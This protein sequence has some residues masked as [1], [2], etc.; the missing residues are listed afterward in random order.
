VC[1]TPAASGAVAPC[2]T[3][4]ARV[5]LS[6]KELNLSSYKNTEELFKKLLEESKKYPRKFGWTRNAVNSYGDDLEQVKNC[7]Y[8]FSATEAENCRY[9]FFIP[10]E[11]KETYDVDHVGVGAEFIL[12][13]LS[14]FHDSRIAFGNRIYS[15]SDVFY[16]DDCHGSNNLFGCAGLRSKEYCILNKQYSKDEYLSLRKRIIKHMDEMPFEGKNGRVYKYGEFFPV[17]MSPFAY[18]EVVCQE[19]FQLTKDE[20]EAKGYRWRDSKKRRYDTT[21]Q[22]EDLPDNIEEVEDDILKQIVGCAHKGECD[23]QCVTAFK[24]TPQELQFLKAMKIPLPRLCPNCRHYQRL[25]QRNPLKL[26]HKQC[27]C[28]YK[29]YENTTKHQHHP[30]GKCPNEF[31]TSYAPNRKEIVYCEQC[32]QAEVV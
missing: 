25:K 16:S 10:T 11:A 13:L 2:P 27:V 26:W 4:H 24:I 17:E 32:Y 18:N 31:E 7:Y 8:C 5:S 14:G 29:V 22:P 23:E 15:S 1:T 30:E 9:S 21:V 19:Y 6:L 3:V 12:E 20:T 28:D